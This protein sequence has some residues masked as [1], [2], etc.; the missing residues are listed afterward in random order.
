MPNITQTQTTNFWL[1]PTDPRRVPRRRPVAQE[2]PSGTP[3]TPPPGS[4]SRQNGSKGYYWSSSKKV[5]KKCT[6]LKKVNDKTFECALTGRKK[7]FFKAMENIMF[8]KPKHKTKKTQKTECLE[9]KFFTS[10]N[11]MQED[12]QK[13]SEARKE[14]MHALETKVS[15]TEKLLKME[16]E[17]AEKRLNFQ[18]AAS[19]TKMKENLEETNNRVVIIEKRQEAFTKRL[20]DI[21][22]KHNE[23]FAR[24]AR[25]ERLRANN[26]EAMYNAIN[27]RR[28]SPPG[29]YPKR[30]R[31]FERNNRKRRRF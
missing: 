22:T 7:T 11:A 14:E 21:V 29:Y 9:L 1:N 10:L 6:I 2:V 23:S 25:R 5:W 28:A 12:R 30:R 3:Q 19:E 27:H 15:T 4:N 16:I 31:E 8:T 26:K 18:I 24:I 20:D 13:E 17:S